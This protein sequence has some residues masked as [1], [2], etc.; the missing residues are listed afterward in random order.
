MNNGNPTILVA[1][2]E[3][4]VAYDLQLRLK[5]MEYNVP[6][7]VSSGEEILEKISQIKPDIILLDIMLKGQLDGIETAQIIKDKYSYP[8][9]Y[10]TASADERTL[11]RAKTTDSYGYILKPF[12]E[13]KLKSIIDIA[14]C[15]HMIQHQ[16]ENNGSWQFAL[17]DNNSLAII[18][19]D[20]NHNI[21]YLNSMGYQLLSL[22]KSSKEL[23]TVDNY[24]SFIFDKTSN[25]V[26]P[27]LKALETQKIFEVPKNTI[28][29]V[30]N[31]RFII[32]GYAAPIIDSK[33]KV[34]G[35]F[36]IINKI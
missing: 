5:S 30:N 17:L 32:E 15:R 23:D 34:I 8:I 36:L 12:D 13:K 11:N 28:M 6:L 29:K 22:I 24:F 10:L 31:E 18:T 7:V 16:I 9:I 2:D 19:I 27:L 25:A 35:S 20:L 3:F 4:I 14:L 33:N 1:E 26:N 21:K